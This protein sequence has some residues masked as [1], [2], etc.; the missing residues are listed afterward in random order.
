MSRKVFISYSHKDENYREDLEEHL[1]ILQSK[2]IIEI[3]HDR[4]ITA[5]DE[6]K[7]QIDQNLDEADIIFF[8]ISSSFLASPYCRDVEV[9]RALERYNAGTATIISIIVRPCEWADCEFSALQAVPK[10]AKAITEW[11]NTDRAWLDA[12]QGIKRHIEKFHPANTIEEIGIDEHNTEETLS[13]KNEFLDWLNDTE[14]VL[15]HRRLDKVKLDDVYTVPDLEFEDDDALDTFPIKKGEYIHENQGYFLVSG[16]EQQGKTSYLKYLYK[17]NLKNGM[18]PIYLNA[19]NIK[20]SDLDKVFKKA[21]SEQYNGLDPKSLKS[22]DNAV[23]YLDNLDEI[24]LNPKFR[25]ILIENLKK[26]FNYIVCTC[27]SSFRYVSGEIPSLDQFSRCEILPFGNKKREEIVKKWISAGIEESINEVDL[28]TQCDDLKSRL[29]IVIKRNIVPPK[30]IYVLMLLQMF[31]AHAQLNLEL[32]SYGHCYQQLIYQSFEKAKISTQEFEKYLNVLTELAWWIFTNGTD[33]NDA[34]LDD[35][36]EEYEETFLAVDK[37]EVI[38]KLKAHAILSLKGVRTGFKYPYIYYFF[39]GK[40]IAESYSESEQVARQV[41]IILEKL[42]RE[43]FANILIFITHHTKDSW[44][45]EK[46]QTVLS[47]LFSDNEEATLKR[48]QLAFMDDFISKIPEL[49]IEQREVQKER[50]LHNERMDIIERDQ[51]NEETDEDIS[52]DIL[53]SINKTFKGMEV[54]GQIIRNRHS[55]LKRNALIQLAGGGI[56]CGLRFLDY[57]IVISDS[58]KNEIINLISNHLAEYPNLTDQEI[59]KVAENAYQQLTYGVINS[60]IR[61]ISSSVGSKEALEIYERLEDESGTPAY[62]LIKQA[63]ELQFTRKLSVS[64][65]EKSQEKLKNN[66]VCTRILKEL[67]VQHIYMFPVDYKVKQQLSDLLE[68]PVKTQRLFDRQTIG[69]G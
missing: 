14:I 58:A 7:G 63:I 11:E 3:W 57:F 51:S 9:K 6:W 21:I 28:Y 44:V 36:F 22:R 5:G 1:S 33:P 17:E 66:P 43:D 45:I 15:A 31:E 19:E 40:K 56:S 25:N 52:N 37:N 10:D 48:E 47:D 42:H 26:D 24:G 60:L 35:F 39:V 8:M 34:Q 67:V 49:I 20:K 16:E 27:H 2:G 12:V 41:D 69:K 38:N 32:T 62:I 18:M 53:A 61:K 55:S 68:I 64:S 29:N 4:K 23:I 13:V 54:A 50:D 59:E 30:P 65:V 46:I